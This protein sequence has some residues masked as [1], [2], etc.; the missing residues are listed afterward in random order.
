MT[1]ATIEKRVNKTA[2]EIQALIEK[3]KRKFLELEV[4][5]SL[6]EIKKGKFEIFKT[7]EEL[8]KKMK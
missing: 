6:N 4:I 5:L 7:T 3:S 1:E 2:G 8:F